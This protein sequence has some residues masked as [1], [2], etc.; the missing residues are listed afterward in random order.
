[1]RIDLLVEGYVDATVAS[2]LLAH[3]DHET[4]TTYGKQGWNY[5][6]Q[7]INAFD[8]SLGAS[9]LLT[10][11]DFMDTGAACPGALVQEW[12][13]RPAAAHIFRLVVREIESWILADRRG[14]ADFLGISIVK[15]P[16]NPEMIADPKQAMIN[17]A[18]GARSKAL[19]EAMVPRSGQAASE[20]PLYSTEL[21]RFIIDHWDPEVAQE[22]SPSLAR[23]IVR[24]NQLHNV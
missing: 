12:L 19:R 4:G 6:A 17:L 16:S 24:L 23:C 10:L 15:I 8:K 22:N 9:G 7:K 14:V 11:V 2:R 20:G 18:R 3:C 21:A 13:P 1:M 5:I